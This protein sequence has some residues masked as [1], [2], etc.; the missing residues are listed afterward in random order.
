MRDSEF[1]EKLK[2]AASSDTLYVMGCFGAPL[3]EFN[4]SRY[5]RNHEYN[6]QPTRRKMINQANEN[7]FGFD[8]VNLI[9]GIL[10]GWDRNFTR[11]YGGAVYESNGVPDVG[12]DR[13][14][15][16]LCTLRTTDFSH[17]VPGAAVWMAGHIGVYVGSGHVIECS[18][19]WKNGVQYTNLGNLGIREDNWREWSEWGF[20]KF[21]EYTNDRT[22]YPDKNGLYNS[23]DECPGWTR[24]AVKWFINE[25][26]IQGTNNNG[27][28]GLDD[29][30]V[31]MLV[32]LYRTLQ[33]RGLLN[34][35]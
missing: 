21:I 11:S 25:H 8:C 26:I 27:A 16:E 14:F 6:K 30:T 15:R 3:N 19:R 34:D 4:K 17:I 18:P 29:K 5:V 28:L 9:K 35:E 24:D 1:I 2:L 31:R 32:I 23:A 20:I 33:N 10:W 13:F 22:G 7:C 12:A